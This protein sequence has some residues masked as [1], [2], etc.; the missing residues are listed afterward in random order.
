VR[1]FG[2]GGGEEVGGY[3][4]SAEPNHSG[5]LNN[6][7]RVW[8]A[9]HSDDYSGMCTQACSAWVNRG[10]TQGLEVF[11]RAKVAQHNDAHLLPVEV[12]FVLAQYVHLLQAHVA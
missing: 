4:A 1:V 8:A 5:Q 2:G 6:K 9:G 7:T 3:S 12:M 10:P 11:L